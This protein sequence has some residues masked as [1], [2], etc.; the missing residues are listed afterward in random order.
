MANNRDTYQQQHTVS[1][2]RTYLSD[3]A[4][5]QEFKKNDYRVFLELLTQLDGYNK[6]IRTKKALESDPMNF[7][8]IDLKAISE[9]LQLEKSEMK[10]ILKKLIN[11][12]VIEKG[13]NDS[14]KNGYRF[15]F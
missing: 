1:I 13:S 9:K 14:I 6:S 7:K 2:P 10:K 8:K 3:M 11:N 5:D 15:T 4:C 12:G